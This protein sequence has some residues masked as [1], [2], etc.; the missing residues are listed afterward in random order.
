MYAI[1]LYDDTQHRFMA[2]ELIN[3]FITDESAVKD[4]HC[5]D[6]LTVKTDDWRETRI[7]MDSDDELYGWYF[8]GVGRAAPL[9]GHSVIV[10]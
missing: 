10:E 5:G 4:L 8:V 2:Q 9:I 3:G 1:L 7:E 6:C